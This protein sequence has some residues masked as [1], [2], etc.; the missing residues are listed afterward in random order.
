MGKS[1]DAQVVD[2]LFRQAVGF[3]HAVERK[4]KCKQVEFDERGRKVNEVESL[5]P[6]QDTVYIK[7][8]VTAQR[9]WLQNRMP[10]VW[11]KEVTNSADDDGEIDFPETT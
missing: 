3:E 6:Y 11:G 4:Q 10:K 5:E 7:P 9:F 8:S 1:R 2:A